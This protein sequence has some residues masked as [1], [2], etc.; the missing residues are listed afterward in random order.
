[1]HGFYTKQNMLRLRRRVALRKE[2][3]G[4]A[5][6]YVGAVLIERRGAALTG[7]LLILWGPLKALM[8]GFLICVLILGLGGPTGAHPSDIPQ[9]SQ[10][11]KSQAMLPCDCS[12]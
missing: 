4:T 5:A 11:L 12:E 7:E 1:M 2:F 9:H 6:L 3:L 10:S 8:V